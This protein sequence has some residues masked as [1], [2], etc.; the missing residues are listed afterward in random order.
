M[1]LRHHR[2]RRPDPPDFTLDADLHFQPTN[3]PG[4]RLAHVWLYRHD[5]GAEVSTLDLCGHGRITLLTGPG[6]EPW[7]AAAQEMARD[8]GIEVAVHV[9]GPRQPHVDNSGDWARASEVADNGCLLVRPGHRVA[10]RADSLSAAPRENLM[11]VLCAILA[12]KAAKT[13]RG[14]VTRAASFLAF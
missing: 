12:R 10:W 9:I 8:P 14:A 6:G 1:P 4:A 5:S 11:P 3:W 2:Y 7:V 13:D